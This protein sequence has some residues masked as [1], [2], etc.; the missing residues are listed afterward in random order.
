[1]QLLS[2]ENRKLRL[3]NAHRL[4]RRLKTVENGVNNMK[5]WIIPS[6]IRSSGCS[7]NGVFLSTNRASL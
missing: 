2:A 4:T 1:M 7:C 6:C 5:A 3:Y